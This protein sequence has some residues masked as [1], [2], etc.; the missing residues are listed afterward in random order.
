[1]YTSS[2]SHIS[3]VPR[4]LDMVTPSIMTVKLRLKSISF[5]GIAAISG[6]THGGEANVLR[7]L[8]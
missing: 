6:F 1:M 2:G 3:L 7:A 8:E 4:L 5:R